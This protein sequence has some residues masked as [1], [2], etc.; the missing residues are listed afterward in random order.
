MT[1]SFYRVEPE[2]PAALALL[3]IAVAGI[4]VTSPEVWSSMGLEATTAALRVP[5]EGLGWFAAYVPITPGFVNAARVLVFATA[6]SGLVGFFSRVSFS[7]LAVT[8]FY[9]FGCCEL[10][11][12]TR[13]NMHLFWFTALLAASPCGAWWS[14]DAARGSARDDPSSA[15]LAVWMAR[16]LFASVYFFPGFW[17]LRESG[18]HWAWSD[19][20]RNQMYWKWYE[21]AW[22]PAF[23]IDLHPALVRYGAAGVL[24]LEL[25]FPLLIWS[26]RGRMVAALGALSFHLFADAF[27]RLGFSSLWWC[28]APLLDMRRLLDWLYETKG[29]AEPPG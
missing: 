2:A 21:N 26:R 15:T 17:K 6:L 22:Q 29:D 11:G 4:L 16:I 1:P 7:A 5:P 19:N 10:V 13:H 24:L 8:S 28:Y 12:A 23:R 25:A 18:L 3:R 9:L 20:L 14:V 27:M